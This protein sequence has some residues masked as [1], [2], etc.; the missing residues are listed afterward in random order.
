MSIR[1]RPHAITW[2]VLASWK[3][4]GVLR[5]KPTGATAPPQHYFTV[6]G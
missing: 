6:S 1:M 4:A 2:C 5:I 3:M